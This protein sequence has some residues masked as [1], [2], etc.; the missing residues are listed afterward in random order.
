MIQGIIASLCATLI[1]S[2]GIF[3]FR[4]WG[5][6]SG[7]VGCFAFRRSLQLRISISAI[8]KIAINNKLV[9]IRMPRRSEAFGPIGGVVKFYDAAR[10][11]L[12]EIGF[13]AQLDDSVDDLR[14]FIPAGR[15]LYFYQ[16]LRSEEDRESVAECLRR[17]LR[18]ELKEIG[19][20]S[21]CGDIDGL[22][23]RRVHIVREGPKSP[24][25][26]FS[27]IQ[28]RLFYVY[29]IPLSERKNREFAEKIFERL[30]AN[31][32]LV[33]VSSAEIIKGRIEQG[34]IGS[35]AC[36]LLTVRSLR[37]DLPPICS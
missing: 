11:R 5:W 8:L 33:A 4:N 7:F 19:E 17:E 15:V 3:V 26:A 25:E 24:G 20:E 21:L 12:G 27:Y 18:E 35:H 31:E 1:A 16:W 23:F 34:L 37:P 6:L 29:E 30:E 28:F 22:R 13:A 36:Y 32:N 10:R 14:G 9:L 2:T